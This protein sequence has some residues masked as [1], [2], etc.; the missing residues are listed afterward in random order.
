MSPSPNLPQLS[1]FVTHQCSQ[2]VFFFVF[3][4]LEFRVSFRTKGCCPSN[5]SMGIFKKGTWKDLCVANWDVV[6]RN[7]VCQAQGYNGSSLENHSKSGTNSLGN[8]TYSC[9]QLTQNCE[10]KFNTEIKCSGILQILFYP[11]FATVNKTTVW[12]RNSA[13]S[14]AAYL[15]RAYNKQLFL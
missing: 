11:K 6:E 10:E 9:E 14:L 15:P 4:F 5:G 2:H 7:L 1:E 8:T 13:T 3:F 12:C